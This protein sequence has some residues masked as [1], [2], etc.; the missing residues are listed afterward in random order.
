[1]ITFG[2]TGGIASGKSTVTKVFRQHDIPI[3]DA[4]VIARQVVE[5]G[6]EGLS[7]VISAFGEEYLDPDGQLDRIKLGKLVFKSKIALIKLMYIM[8]PLIKEESARQIE[9]LHKEYS[10]IGYDAA[11]IIEMGNA[12]KYRPL[13]LVSCPKEIQL[14]RLM[15]RNNLSKEEALSRIN[16]QLPLEVKTKYADYIID[17][18]GSIDNS[19]IQTFSIIQD[20]KKLDR[21]K[22]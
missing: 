7:Q 12:D 14:S 15:S 4:D 9:R 2:L 17:T 16:A 6:T 1:M 19:Q 8:S 21:K 11:L 20:L 22:E 18:S 13:I 5:P 10:I 3:V